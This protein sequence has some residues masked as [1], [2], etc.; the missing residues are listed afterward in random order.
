MKTCTTFLLLLIFFTGCS[1]DEFCCIDPENEIIDTWLLFERGWSPGN[2]YYVDPVSTDPPQTMEIRSDG[3][4]SSNI[5]DLEK[6]RYFAI[7]QHQDWEVLALFQDKPP[8]EPD[9]DKV[10]HRYIIEFQE[11]GTV[12]LYFIFCDEGCH[13]GLRRMNY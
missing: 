6:Y 7:L 9:F 8:K 1:E 10:E 4:F 13:L 3:R 2:G 5:Q 11:N 12:K